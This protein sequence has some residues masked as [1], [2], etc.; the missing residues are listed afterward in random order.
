LDYR[1]F[2]PA[3]HSSLR[4][5]LTDPLQAEHQ[6]ICR[7]RIPVLAV[8]AAN[9]EII[10]ITCKDTLSDWN[11]EAVQHVI[12]GAGHGVTY[13]HTEEVLAHIIPEF[14]HNT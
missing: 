10:P 4:N 7:A 5:M 14:T 2:L 13:T 6:N 9:D 12:S 1:G 3:V 11:P 8:W